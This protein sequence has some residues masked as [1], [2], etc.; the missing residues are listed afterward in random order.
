MKV[1]VL[2]SSSF[3]AQGLVDDRLAQSGHEVWSFDRTAQASNKPRA[4]SGSYEKAGEVLA[5]IGEC[6]V[7]I[8]FAIVKFGT[9]E[10]NRALLEHIIDAARAVRAKLFIQVSSISVLPSQVSVVDES[11]PAGEAKWK[12]PY[13]RIKA[14][15]EQLLLKEWRDKPLLF[16]RPGFLLAEGIVDTMV[17]IGR[18]LPGGHVLGLGNRERLSQLFDAR[19]SMKH[20]CAS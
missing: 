1:L 18:A 2:G 3:A 19:L 13:A 8:N 4:L 14:D 17:G 15:A 9:V 11:M 20:S 7:I 10:E 5:E 12:G 16:V 6:D